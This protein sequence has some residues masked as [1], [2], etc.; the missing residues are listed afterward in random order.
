MEVRTVTSLQAA[1]NDYR[2]ARARLCIAF[3]E[4]FPAGSVV[5]VDNPCFHGVGILLHLNPN[6]EYADVY[7][8]SGNT[9]TYRVETIEEVIKDVRDW[10]H[11][12]RET[13]LR[14]KL[15]AQ[16]RREATNGTR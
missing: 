11:W 5:Q 13:K 2:D 14:W 1:L 8:Q 4:L 16:K 15:E 10:P 3:N 12:V 7:L 9:W 6:P